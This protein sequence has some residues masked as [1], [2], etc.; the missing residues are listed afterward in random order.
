MRFRR[1]VIL[2]GAVVAG[3]LLV[4]FGL[5]DPSFLHLGSS[6]DPAAVAAGS[7]SSVAHAGDPA[8]DTLT[9]GDLGE[10]GAESPELRALRMTE[11][12]LMTHGPVV[13]T[14]D[15]VPGG[16]DQPCQ[17][18]ACGTPENT[19][20]MSGL[21]MPDLPIHPDAKVERFVNYFTKNNDGRKLFR[22][23]LQ[24][25]GRYRG[26]VEPAL[27][28]KMLPR[29]LMALVA[30]ESGFSPTAVSTAGATGLWQFMPDTA[31]AYGL[32][33]ESDYDERRSVTRATDA[34]TR[35][36]ADLYDKFGSWELALAAY[37]MGY[38]GMLNVVRD[39][40]SNDF[41]TLS[42]IT[43]ALPE[44]SVLYVPKIMAVALILNNLERFGFDDVHFD[45]PIPTGNLEVPAGVGLTTIARAA[46]TS[47]Q[48]LR[49]L[50][51]E[52]LADAIPNRGESFVTHVPGE[53]LARARAMLPRLLDVDDR[54]G[55]EHSVSRSFDWGRDE[56]PRDGYA[57]RDDGPPELR[58]PRR[59][60]GSSAG[61]GPSGAPQ[62]VFYRIGSSETLAEVARMF[63]TTPEE[64]ASANYL[65]P[66]AK[67]QK[68]M[69]LTINGSPEAM[70]RMAR[71]RA[72]ARL[73]RQDSSADAP[74]PPRQ[75]QALRE[76]R[77]QPRDQVR[78]VP[79][80]P[81]REE[82]HP[83]ARPHTHAAT[84]RADAR[85]ATPEHR[86]H[87]GD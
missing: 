52:L 47:V 69:M 17:G 61:D 3:G 18:A 27:H 79:R 23:L 19:E 26:I 87:V 6:P 43:G 30:V 36:L 54:D 49:E 20:W 66:S 11:L 68:G 4:G 76:V 59:F 73:E 38:K 40:G 83:L 35:L 9:A 41:W 51:P 28:D 45:P 39:T 13:D 57:V 32:A 24:R 25:S 81:G 15:G 67:L 48:R 29:D 84:A 37:N 33:V 65:D 46:G 62:T 7:S 58:K 14:P 78:E 34:G 72:P 42:K 75:P 86:T 12:S 74:P 53:G 50:N 1:G 60:L 44:E 2:Y 16:T 64:I 71:R 5:P 22:A 10:D 70:E 80:E 56:L 21:R 85:A 31:R 8:E 55:L 82:S 77:E 63:G